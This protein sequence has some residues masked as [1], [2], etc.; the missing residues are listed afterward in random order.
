M[1]ARRYVARRSAQQRGR[2]SA[3]STHA[4]LMLLSRAS[5]FDGRQPRRENCYAARCPAKRSHE[6]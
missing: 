6:H 1:R 3:R 2:L 5:T 4:R